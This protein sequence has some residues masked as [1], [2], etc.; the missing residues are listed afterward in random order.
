MAGHEAAAY[1]AKPGIL[2]ETSALGGRVELLSFRTAW[3]EPTAL[4]RI[5][6]RRDQ[7]LD[8]RQLGLLGHA[9]L[10]DA[11]EQA[12]GIR[13]FAPL[14]DLD[15]VTL[16]HDS[17]GIHD[18]NLVT[19]L[20]NNAHVVGDEDDCS[21]SAFLKILGQVENLSLDRHVQ[22]RRGFVG[23]EELRLTEKCHRDHDTLFHPS[24]QLVRVGSEALLGI[25]D[26]DRSE[27]LRGALARLRSS[28]S[29]TELQHLPHLSLDREH[30]VQRGHRILED[31]RDLF[32][33]DVRQ[34]FGRESQDVG[35][36]KP[37]LPTE[38]LTG[39]AWDEPEDGRSGNTFAAT[40]LPDDPE[41]SARVDLKGH[42]VHCVEESVLGL[43][44]DL[45]V[46]DLE[47]AS[48]HLPRRSRIP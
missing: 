36:R 12:L 2:T 35:A 32:S 29:E 21:A 28:Q 20:G 19:N 41:G 33:P 10:R 17:P 23:D 4:R 8:G 13:M 43:E 18:G 16:L 37:D 14:E 7:A 31:H 11:L 9:L 39:R 38:D 26:P 47:K 25:R 22:S 40:R 24:G 3:G 45:E 44:G 15:H 1:R 48:A 27:H 46:V 6:Q 34:L 42:T 5:Q 30:R